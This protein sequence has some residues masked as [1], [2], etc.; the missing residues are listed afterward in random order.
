MVVGL[1]LA[2]L[3]CLSARAVAQGSDRAPRWEIP[4]FDISTDGGWRVKAR[5]VAAERAR[6]LRARDFQRLNAAP[7]AAPSLAATVV[8]GT[9]YVPLVLFYYQ[10]VAIG[11]D[12]SQYDAALFST[13]PPLGR[14]YTLR[15]FYDQMSDGQLTMLGQAIGWALLDSNEVAITGNPATTT[16]TGNPA[17][18]GMC[19]GLFSPDA[20]SRMQKGLRAALGKVDGGVNFGQFDND[21]PDGTPNSGDD[22]G[23]VDMLGFGHATQD[24]A[25]S[26]STNN[27]IWAH[28]W[29]LGAG[30]GGGFY[31]TND[32]RS[33]GGSIL[34]RDY[35][36]QSALGGSTSCN[37]GEIM[38]I[39][40]AAHEFGHAL[41]LPDLYDTQGSTEGI[42]RWGLMGSG[43]Y[44]SPNSPARMESWSLNEMGWITV[45]P[46]TTSGT[47]TLRP[48]QTRDSV[49]TIVPLGD[50]PRSELFLIENRQ[51][52]EG[53]TAL[54]RNACQVWHQADI[55][56][57]PGGLLIWHVDGQQIANG[58][59][60]NTVNSATIHGL[61]LE[62][63]D[64]ERDLWCPGPTGPGCNRGDAGDVYPG[65]AAKLAF[66][67]ATTPAPVKNSDGSGTGIEIDQ[68]T[69][70]VAGGEMSFRVVIDP[71]VPVVMESTDPRP[72]GV[73]GATYSDQLVATGGTGTFT[74]TLRSGALPAG[75]TLSSTGV[76]SGI[77]AA[78]GN[79][80][81]IVRASSGINF[82]D[83]SLS[84]SVTAPALTLANVLAQLFDV[85]ATTLTADE[86]RYLDLN[87]NNNG[88]FDLGDFKRW[89]D[90]GG[91]T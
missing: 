19:N 47:Y 69:Q 42:G 89:R 64:G 52:L 40:T 83:Q 67:L 32:A 91:G 11:P 71:G 29:V 51:A 27:H 24:G 68:I 90:Q 35:F 73:M 78:T 6:L 26:S 2:S 56:N 44:S 20:R 16:C 30:D 76:I 1:A 75:V 43:N 10:D 80:S 22:D 14:P 17:G 5:R 15:T 55:T 70:V 88:I 18:G 77:P 57:C 86:M 85:S 48:V 79:Y 39:G 54:I 60:S 38:A 23:V 53:D 81:F 21:G 63:A 4:G 13:T 34:I 65:Q 46:I 3:C 41:G 66:T 33:G 74:W 72:A 84:I 37:S 9:I 36:I 82:A 58:F 7:A 61:E 12:I 50:N 28:R 45:V 87:G 25:C 62:E 49:Y 31:V 59:F 8:T